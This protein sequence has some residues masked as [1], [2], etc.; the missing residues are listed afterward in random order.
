MRPSIQAMRLVGSTLPVL[1]LAAFFVRTAGR[2]GGETSRSPVV[3][4]ALLFGTPLFAYGLLLFSHALV[5][6]A[7]FGAWAALFVPGAPRES[8]AREIAA[9]A[10][11]GLAVLSEYPAAIPALILIAAAAWK[12]EPRRLARVALGGAPFAAVLLVWNRISFGGF[13]ELSSAHE[14][15]GEFRS[16]AGTGVFGIGLPSPG[17][18]LGLLADPSKGLLVF[19]PF[20]ILW[21]RAFFLAG[22]VLSRPAAVSL[23]LVPAALLFL[24][25]GYPNWHGGFTVGPRY[26]V[27]A[28]PFLV[29]PFFF[30]GG[31]RLEAALVGASVGAVTLTSLAFPFVPPGFAFPW[32]SFGGYFLERG[33]GAPNLLHLAGVP[34]AVAAPAVLVLMAALVSFE[35][36]IKVATFCFGMAVWAGTGLVSVRLSPPPPSLRLQRAYVEDVYFGRTGALEKEIATTGVPQPRLLARRDREKALPPSDWPF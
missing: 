18:L 32:A 6:F 9:G 13:F 10:L 21:P 29:F 14:K 16:L 22:R 2:L 24:Y 27:A 28:F 25:A 8:A 4:L 20:L 1:L 15:L 36:R 31:G 33:L 35:E 5:A 11:L 30:R 7:L 17:A 3:L 23:G 26:L 34:V 12:R 19:S